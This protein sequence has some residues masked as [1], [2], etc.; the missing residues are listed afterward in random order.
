MCI[1]TRKM[2]MRQR[3]S[4]PTVS[5]FEYQIIKKSVNFVEAQWAWN[6]E[7]GLYF[8]IKSFEEYLKSKNLLE[9]FDA[10]LKFLG[11]RHAR[12]DDRYEEFK[13]ELFKLPILSVVGEDSIAFLEN[14]LE[15]TSMEVVADEIL[16]YYF[17]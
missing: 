13:E 12:P 3:L 14:N 8:K 17:G 7:E 5:S 10:E 9:A 2:S 6:S 11:A 4:K 1:K 16:M 15:T